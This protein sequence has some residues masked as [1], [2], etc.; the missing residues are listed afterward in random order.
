[1]HVCHQEQWT[2]G[3]GRECFVSELLKIT[4]AENYDR[5]LPVNEDEDANNIHQSRPIFQI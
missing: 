4:T 1:M 2:D 5:T 3:Q